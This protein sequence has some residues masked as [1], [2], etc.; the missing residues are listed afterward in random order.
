MPYITAGIS[1]ANI[2]SSFTQSIVGS[3]PL[4][5]PRTFNSS[6]RKLGYAFGG[7]IKWMI[8]ESFILGGEYLFTNYGNMKSNATGYMPPEGGGNKYPVTNL[9]TEMYSSDF[10]LNLEYKF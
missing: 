4:N 1:S 3:P 6:E 7:G 8:N 5:L 10:K 2:E 9:N